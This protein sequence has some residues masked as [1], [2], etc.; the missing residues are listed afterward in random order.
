VDKF[1]ACISFDSLISPPFFL[2]RVVVLSVMFLSVRWTSFS[3]TNNYQRVI[4]FKSIGQAL[5]ELREPSCWNN[6]N[7]KTIGIHITEHMAS[8]QPTMMDHCGYS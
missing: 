5:T 4:F 2:E 6:L 1:N 7:P 8:V 3:T